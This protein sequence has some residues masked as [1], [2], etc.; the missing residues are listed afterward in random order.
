MAI[1]IQGN[2][3]SVAEVDG[4]GFRAMRVSPRP[5]DAGSLGHYRL[6]TTIPL[7]VTHRHCLPASAVPPS[8]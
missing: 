3:G 8:P 5:V 2:G 6:S 7:V 1:Q 4:T